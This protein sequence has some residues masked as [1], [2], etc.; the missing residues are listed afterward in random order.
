M[1]FVRGITIVTV[2][3]SIVFSLS[4]SAAADDLT[5]TR[6]CAPT[7]PVV[8]LQTQAVAFA[9]RPRSGG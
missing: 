5:T 9:A 8:G 3:V 2:A 7:G 6:G 1:K 4:R